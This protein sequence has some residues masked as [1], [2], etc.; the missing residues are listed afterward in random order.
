M[1]MSEVSGSGSVPLNGFV[2]LFETQPVVVRNGMTLFRTG[3]VDSNVA[4]YPQATQMPWLYPPGDLT[5]SLTTLAG[6]IQTSVFEYRFSR[7]ILAWSAA[8]S[9]GSFGIRS[10]SDLNNFSDNTT[11][12]LTIQSSSA[13][14]LVWDSVGSVLHCYVANHGNR[15][16]TSNGT[17]WT[18]TALS[19]LA[20]HVID[21]IRT[22]TIWVALT[23]AG[24]YSSSDGVSWTQR[25]AWTA[26][27][28]ADN[29]KLAIDGSNNIVAMLANKSVYYSSVNGTS[30]VSQN[31]PANHVSV[32]HVAFGDSKWQTAFKNTVTNTVLAATST[33]F[34]SWT[35]GSTGGV[36]GR[37]NST[38][39]VWMGDPRFGA[40]YGQSYSKDG[41]NWITAASTIPMVGAWTVVSGKVFGLRI[42]GGN[43]LFNNASHLGSVVGLPYSI[44]TVSINA[45]KYLRV[46]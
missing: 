17:S 5:G 13:P 11:A 31:C 21:V 45:N 12:T 15:F 29:G 41:L 35:L 19:G 2:D 38:L 20:G 27:A 18:T 30:W 26:D 46:K 14:T 3:Y 37:W 42:G 33:N 6:N 44:G 9:T 4:N 10:S 7:L 28:V 1:K 39:G 34:T 40:T 16:N 32:G 22:P 43:Y 24:I 36:V 25:Q 8:S 23:S